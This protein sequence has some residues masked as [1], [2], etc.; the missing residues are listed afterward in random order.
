[1]NDWRISSRAG[2]VRD[3]SRRCRLAQIC[4]DRFMLELD[5]W[6]ALNRPR[7]AERPA[8]EVRVELG[9]PEEARR[10]VLQAPERYGDQ[11]P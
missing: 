1:M 5:T 7:P 4:L 2:A 11:W 6:D 9:L 8:E 3:E 10:A